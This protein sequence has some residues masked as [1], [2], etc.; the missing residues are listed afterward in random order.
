[1]TPRSNAEGDR[2]RADRVSLH[3]SFARV[4][5]PFSDSASQAR[6][7]APT[8]STVGPNY[9]ADRNMA[10]CSG[11]GETRQLFKKLGPIPR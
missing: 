5:N 1:M 9:G 2:P 10:S 8:S 6:E 11:G 7:T 4:P 3:V